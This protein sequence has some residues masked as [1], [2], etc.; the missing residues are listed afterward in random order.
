MLPQIPANELTIVRA[1]QKLTIGRDPQD[2]CR[3][4]KGMIVVAESNKYPKSNSD[5]KYLHMKRRF[6]HAC[7]TVSNFSE[8]E[9]TSCCNFFA[10]NNV[11]NND[12]PSARALLKVQSQSNPAHIF[13]RIFL[14]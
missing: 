14:S 6:S 10:E 5:E 2:G 9:F 11:F 3:I 4:E 13:R 7:N 1:L 8:D 12:S